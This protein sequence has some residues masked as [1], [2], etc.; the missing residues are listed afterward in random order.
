MKNVTEKQVDEFAD[1]I[2]RRLGFRRQAMRTPSLL[3]VLTARMESTGCDSFESY[4]QRLTGA[5][6]REEVRVLG[7]RLSVP[8]TY[9]FRNE[10]H[11]RALR[12]A[13]LPALAARR[14]ERRLRV[15]SA[16]CATGE[17]P[18]SLAIA[19]REVLGDDWDVKVD[20]ADI[21]AEVLDRAAQA[22]Y[23]PWSLRATPEAV[24]DRYFRAS[25]GRFE[26]D[27]IVRQM[28]RFFEAN[29]LDAQAA[30]WQSPQAYDLVFCR[31]MLM[32]LTPEAMRAV[33]ARIAEAM[34]DDAY[35]FIGHAETLRGVTDAF[36]LCHTH[37]TFYYARRRAVA[38]VDPARRDAIPPAQRPRADQAPEAPTWLAAI[39]Q[40]S[41]RIDALLSDSRAEPEARTPREHAAT[42]QPLVAPRDD[43]A[44]TIAL[45]R[46]ERYEEALE[47]VEALP[48]DRHDAMLVRAA[49]LTNAGRVEE[50]ERACGRLLER[51]DM[52]A[53]A[54]YLMALCREH[55]GDVEGALAHDRT[56]VYLDP[57]FAMPRLHIGLVAGRAG[58]RDEAVES[59]RQAESL[60]AEE[61]VPRILMFGGGFGRESLVA[62]CRAQL[63]RYEEDDR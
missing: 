44:E 12:E 53:G 59:L 33:V 14:S 51:D 9:F 45:M 40:S 3:E 5:P 57:R 61:S 26:L 16:G 48:G 46:E 18:Y 38:L 39:D 32:Y 25:A 8:E 49:L 42:R 54:H 47:R 31:N 37:G 21:N 19:A 60:L 1:W 23:R 29:L 7:Q 50:A 35:L 2:S 43:L 34:R 62:L 36:S 27:P 58:R 11:F 4:W 63:K 10:D 41:A 52:D 17:E 56:A 22:S 6:G 24:R 20:A 15:L 55:V 30:T 13:V 28:V